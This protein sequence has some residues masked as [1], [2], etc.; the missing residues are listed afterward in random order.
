MKASHLV[1]L[2]LMNLCWAGVY[3]AYKIIDQDLGGAGT[4]AA[5]VTLRFG[6]AGFCLLL[7]WPLLPGPAPRGRDLFIVCLM[8]VTLFVI[9]QRLQVYGNH[10]GTAGNSSVLMAVEPLVTSLAGAI[11]LREH[12]GPRRWVGFTLGLGGVALLN[13]V[14]TPGFKLVGLA[15]SLIFLSSFICEAA[16]SV[17]GKPVILRGVSVMKVLAISLLIGL[18]LN[19]L[20]DGQSTYAA[21]RQLSLTSWGLIVFPGHCLHGDRLRPLVCCHSRVPAERRRFDY[22]RAVGVWRGAGRSLGWGRTALGPAFRQPD[23][24]R[25][26]G[27]GTVAPDQEAFRAAE[28]RANFLKRIAVR[29]PSI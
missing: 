2:L 5:I 29:R 6:L 19:V 22:F 11:F 10:I 27:A 17:L 16:Y 15:P 20:I 23:H 14:G 8:G 9:G 1:L 18:A 12:I 4:T 28:K 21:A 3:S 26:A 7:V 24:C 25:R 13:G